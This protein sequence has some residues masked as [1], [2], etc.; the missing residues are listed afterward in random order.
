MPVQYFKNAQI[1]LAD[2]ILT[3]TLEIENGKITSIGQQN[4]AT[5]L[6][7]EGDFLIPGLIELHT[8]HWET[9]LVPRPKIHWNQIA[10][11]QAHDLQLV[12]S[13]I[14]TVFNA[15]RIGMYEDMNLP[16]EEVHKFALTLLDC[17]KQNRL[18]AKHLIHLR[19]EVSSPDV[20][21][22]LQLFDGI[23][24]VKLV[25]LMD[26]TPGQRQFTTFEAYK[27][28]YQRRTGLSDEEFT[29][30][31]NLRKEQYLQYSSKNRETISNKCKSSQIIFA[32]HDDA[33]KQHINEALEFGVF[34]AEFPTTIEAAKAARENNLKI[35]L[36]APNVVRGGSHS[37]NISVTEI[38]RHG[39]LDMLSSDYVPSSLLHSIF[40]LV[41]E[42][43]V[44][45]LPKGITMVTKT[46]AEVMG[47]NDRGEIK[48]GYNADLVRCAVIDNV[49]IVKAVWR[50]GNRII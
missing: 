19:C 50:D 29:K 9:H 36:G 35:L 2:D 38:A 32:S 49:P 34:I 33:T 30:F 20:I 10:A 23:D 40:L 13:G 26:H 7:F 21:S 48:V 41:N 1:V 45:S 17:Q 14:T 5:G 12:G 37:G 47:L 43:K 15:L 46:P 31:A 42:H 11:I 24:D 44:I 3:G 25:S 16:P 18:K 28:Y 39:L 6:D 8:D 4:K 22:G 27:Q